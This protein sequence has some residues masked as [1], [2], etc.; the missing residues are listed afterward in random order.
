MVCWISILG[1]N[2][3]TQVVRLRALLREHEQGLLSVKA[4]PL[5]GPLVRAQTERRRSSSIKPTPQTLTEQQCSV[6]SPR[7]R[8]DVEK[9]DGV[10][11]KNFKICHAPQLKD[12]KNWRLAQHSSRCAFVLHDHVPCAVFLCF[13]LRSGQ[14]IRS[15]QRHKSSEWAHVWCAV[16]LNADLS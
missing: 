10:D 14:R 13:F 2:T 16:F 7:S 3:P 12:C 9:F 11:A 15:L 8:A 6:M 5:S 1:R 4:S